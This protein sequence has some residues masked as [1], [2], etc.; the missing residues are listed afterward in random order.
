VSSSTGK[1]LWKRTDLNLRITTLI[2][3]NRNCT[4]RG[5]PV[6]SEIL[7]PRSTKNETVETLGR[8]SQL[9]LAETHKLLTVPHILLLLLTKQANQGLV[10]VYWNVVVDV[11]VGQRC[12]SLWGGADVIVVTIRRRIIQP[13]LSPIPSPTCSPTSTRC[14]RDIGQRNWQ[15]IVH[16]RSQPRVVQRRQRTGSRVVVR[17]VPP[18]VDSRLDVRP[19]D[20]RQRL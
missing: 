17:A 15:A 12:S 1:V 20:G 13:S 6:R 19:T 9:P 10:A 16:V 5:S 7:W 2:H 8:V 11:S 4:L 18:E 3:W 14:P